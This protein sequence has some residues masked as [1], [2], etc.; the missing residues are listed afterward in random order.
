MSWLDSRS[1]FQPNSAPPRMSGKTS[2]PDSPSGTRRL[3]PSGAPCTGIGADGCGAD[4]CW[5][6]GC[7]AATA[8]A[9]TSGLAEE[10]AEPTP[11]RDMCHPLTRIQDEIFV[12]ASSAPPGTV[13]RGYAR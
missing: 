7:G 3:L 6:D 9:E 2:E 4:G 5:A 8:W 11:K 13:P 1:T 12:I 10:T